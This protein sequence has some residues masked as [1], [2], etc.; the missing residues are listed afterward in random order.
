MKQKT[1]VEAAYCGDP[2][3]F[4]YIC[5]FYFFNSARRMSS[6]VK[7]LNTPKRIRQLTPAFQGAPKARW[8]KL[9]S[10]FPSTGQRGHWG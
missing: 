6:Q 1:P 3:G 8:K 4:L 7:R 2:R 5:T 9:N 10:A